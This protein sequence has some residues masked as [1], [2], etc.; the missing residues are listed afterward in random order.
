MT[1]QRNNSLWTPGG[2][3]MQ[4]FGECKE[5]HVG[6]H[7]DPMNV[8]ETWVVVL[9]MTLNMPEKGRNT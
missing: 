7:M 2:Q 1:D 8:P 9:I 6:T 4:I 3:K 5:F